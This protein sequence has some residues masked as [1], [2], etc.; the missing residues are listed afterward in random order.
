MTLPII[1]HCIELCLKCKLS[2]G[3][4]KLT[5]YF[6]SHFCVL[7]CCLWRIWN[8]IS[9]KQDS[10]FDSVLHCRLSSGFNHMYYLHSTVTPR[11]SGSH[12]GRANFHQGN[13]GHDGDGCPC[14]YVRLLRVQHPLFNYQQPDCLA[15]KEGGEDS[16]TTTGAE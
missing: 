11:P 4:L 1:A 10:I 14:S 2:N 7:G 12:H 16:G 5:I 8:C 15:S 6:C 9:E 13:H 3:F